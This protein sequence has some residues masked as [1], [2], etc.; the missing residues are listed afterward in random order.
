SVLR[1]HETRGVESRERTAAGGGEFVWD[2]R[3]E[4]TH[5]D[6]GS[7]GAGAE[8]GV[9]S[10]ATSDHFRE[11]VHG[12]ASGH[13]ESRRALEE[14][15]GREVGGCG[16]H[17]SGGADRIQASA[18][19]SVRDP[20]GS[21]SRAGGASGAAGFQWS[22]GRGAG[23]SVFVS[24][25]GSA[26][27]GD[28]AGGV[29]ERGGVAERGRVRQGV[30][31]GG[32]LSVPLEEEEV[33]GLV[34]EGL[35]IAA[36]NGP[37]LTVASGRLER[38]A[39][40]QERLRER[41]VEGRRL[42]TSHAFHS[43]MMEVVLEEFRGVLQRVQLKAPRKRYLSNVTGTWIKEEEARD[44]NYWVRHLRETVRFGANVKELLGDGERVLLEVGPGN[45][46]GGLARRQGA[47]EG[48]GSLR[49]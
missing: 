24:R 9:T 35:W 13:G 23:S 36:V 39:E 34:G 21:A 29:C 44:P 3:D 8:R 12:A 7:A 30:E 5:G 1:K 48:W 27:R 25:G 20:G 32:M 46:L 28:G 38:I 42:E 19:G 43:G 4:R 18:S 40:L 49:G 33:R 10:V 31:A 41:G 26:V 16:L 14:E 45:V 22:D 2:R 11:N 37:G 6:G 47:R 17:A 15:R